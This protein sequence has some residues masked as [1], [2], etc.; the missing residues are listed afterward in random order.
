MKTKTK[1]KTTAKKKA[2]PT[3]RDVMTRKV[4]TVRPDLPV[5]ALVEL[6]ATTKFSGFPVV[7]DG[8]RPVGL[9][10]Q[11]DV[12][13][14]LAAGAGADF[15][16]K[17][18]KA[19]VELLARRAPTSTD[20]LALSVRDLMTPKLV[21]CAPT[22]PVKKVAGAMVKARVHR[23]VVVDE[24]AVAGLVSATDLVRHLGK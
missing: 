9:I 13:R 16:A 3:A 10:S 8:G 24:G 19:A 20:V 22:D 11:N 14:A 18:R 15:Q 1:K 12:L 2:G 6:L 21:A 4:V 23:V 5:A 17:K 7:E